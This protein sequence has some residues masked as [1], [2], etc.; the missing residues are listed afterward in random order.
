MAYGVDKAGENPHVNYE[1]SIMGG[2]AE[3]PKPAKDYHQW[4]EGHL[5]RYETTRTADDYKQAGERYRS[6]ADWERD[7]LVA[8][9][10]DDLRQCPEPI[11]LRMVW[12]WWHCDEDY[13]RRVAE[14]AGIDLEKA[15]ALPP[16]P[17]KPPP[18]ENRPAST[19][20]SGSREESPP[21]QRQSA[22]GAG[23]S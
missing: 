8:N 4:V 12:H 3:A 18:H 14:A 20:T 16:L 6:F 11:Q 1:P 13:G 7:D 23:R 19:Y 21:L 9:I 2:L 10:G 22:A 5:G 17:G 15:K